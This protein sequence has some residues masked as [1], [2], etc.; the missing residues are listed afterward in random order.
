MCGSRKPH[1]VSPPKI[2]VPPRLGVSSA[3]AAAPAPAN[4]SSAMAAASRRAVSETDLDMR[5]P[6]LLFM[7]ISYVFYHKRRGLVKPCPWPRGPRLCAAAFE[8]GGTRGR[9][10]KGMARGYDYVVVGAGI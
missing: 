4:V 8:R 6:L 5:H 2:N 1:S 10:K 9:T 7:C 3:Q